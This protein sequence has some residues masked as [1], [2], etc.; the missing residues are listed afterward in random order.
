M[1]A[2]LIQTIHR[3]KIL[4][5]IPINFWAQTHNY[6]QCLRDFI[7]CFIMRKGWV[8]GNFEDPNFTLI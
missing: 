4:G 7:V 5:N 6:L 2:Y 8:T 1:K 3:E